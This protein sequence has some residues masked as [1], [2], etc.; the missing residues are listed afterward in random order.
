MDNEQHDAHV[1]AFRWYQ[2]MW[3]RREYRHA[4][5]RFDG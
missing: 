5:E 4:G 2:Q 3:M 1:L